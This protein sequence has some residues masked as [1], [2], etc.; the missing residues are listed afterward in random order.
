MQ[1]KRELRRRK[2]VDASICAWRSSSG[3]DWPH[4]SA[5]MLHQVQRTCSVSHYFKPK[6][7]GIEV[8]GLKVEEAFF[9]GRKLQGTTIHLPEGYSGDKSVEETNL[10]T[11]AL[12]IVPGILSFV[13]GKKSSNTTKST[14]TSEGNMNRWETNAKFQ[15]MTFWNHD[16]L[17][18]QDDSYVRSFHWLAVSKAVSFCVIP[19]SYSTWY[20]HDGFV[21]LHSLI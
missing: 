6:H 2:A 7:T 1:S 10:R 13:L 12:L 5:P 9:R 3:S 14:G 4:S 15:A 21:S 17:P 20:S 16:N 8:E 18:S 11:E 19:L